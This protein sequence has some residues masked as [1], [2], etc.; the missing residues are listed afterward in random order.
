MSRA[1]MAAAIRRKRG[2]S[3]EDQEALSQENIDTVDA[4]RWPSTDPSALRPSEPAGEPDP[5]DVAQVQAE[6]DEQEAPRPGSTQAQVAQ[7]VMGAAPRQPAVPMED[8]RDDDEL[9]AAQEADRRSRL[10]AGMELAGRQFVGAV[11]RTPLG[12]GIGAAPSRVPG[13]MAAAKSRAERAAEV[14][15]QRRQGEQDERQGRMDASALDL[16]ASAAEKNRRDPPKG[17]V[18]YTASREAALKLQEARFA[19]EKRKAL[20]NEAL[21]AQVEA[22]K[23]KPKASKPLE[24]IPPGFEVSAGSHPSSETRKKFTQLVSASEKM[25][26][27][28]AKMREALKGTSGMSRTLDPKTVTTLK[29]LGTMIRIEG[30]N[31]AGL[32]ALS[33]PDMGLMDAI[34]SDPTSIKANLTTDLPRMLDQ[35]DSWGDTSVAGDSKANGIVRGAT[36]ADGGRV[37]VVDESGNAITLP[38]EQVDDYLADFPK[39]RR[40]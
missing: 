15:R 32:G 12:Q 19:E 17:G 36:K 25:K 2:L 16:Q 4:F 29:Q 22:R 23:G 27:L 3:P 9:A 13:A 5:A 21:R 40:K 33:G 35:L 14:L 38:A 34:A 28:T 11:T 8:N 37:S 1:L 6:L 10:G 30:K 18:D 31:I 20:V 26:G 24:D 7:S 39:A